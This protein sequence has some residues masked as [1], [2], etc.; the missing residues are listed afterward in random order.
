LIRHRE[1]VGDIAAGT[2]T[3]TSFNVS[4]FVINPGQ[5]ATFQWLSRLAANYESYKFESLSF[6]YETEAPT[7]LGGTLLLAVDYDASDA[8]PGSKQQA[9]AY[10]SSVRSPPW[11]PVKFQATREDLA[12]FKTNFVRTAAQPS[13]T[14]IRTFDIGNLFVISQGVSTASAT[15]GELYVEYAVR[16]M[17]PVSEPNPFVLGGTI[18]ESLVSAAQPF[19][20]DA[21]INATGLE[22]VD[23]KTESIVYFQYAANFIVACNHDGAATPVKLVATTTSSGITVTAGNDA[24][25]VNDCVS[26]LF[27]NV[28]RPGNVTFTMPGAVGG[29]ITLYFSQ[30]PL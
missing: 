3:P 4:A 17:T 7:T 29:N 10:R 25:D 26:F 8:P 21:T 13:G 1:Y 18:Q 11:S 16:L 30:N 14:D 20:V 28:S 24:A 2:G 27:I 6:C 15:L 19:D 23:S 22:I 5:Q 12:K 9:M